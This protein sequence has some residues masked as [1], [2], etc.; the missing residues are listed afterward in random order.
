MKTN[1]KLKVM[2]VVMKVFGVASFVVT[3]FAQASADE[4]IKKEEVIELGL[5]IIDILG[6]KTDIDLSTD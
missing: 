4:V 1:E 6:L 5:G 2:A 3:W